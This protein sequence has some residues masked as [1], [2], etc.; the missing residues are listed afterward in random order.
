MHHKDAQWSPHRHRLVRHRERRTSLNFRGGDRQLLV[1]LSPLRT[2][3]ALVE[4]RRGA[5]RGHHGWVFSRAREPLGA[6]ARSML[7]ESTR[8]I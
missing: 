1:S 7:L 6:S 5:P 3:G 2:P 8:T 4:H